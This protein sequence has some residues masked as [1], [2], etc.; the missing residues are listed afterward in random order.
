MDLEDL[1]A[2][3]LAAAQHQCSSQSSSSD[4]SSNDSK[5]SANNIIEDLAAGK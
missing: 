1:E 2:L 5:Y 4:E 3:E